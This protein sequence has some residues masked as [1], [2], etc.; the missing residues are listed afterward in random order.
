MANITLAQNEY[1]N[2]L[3]FHCTC[4]WD[5]QTLMALCQ[6][7]GW[8]VSVDKLVPESLEKVILIPKFLSENGGSRNPMILKMS[9]ALQI[10]TDASRRKGWDAH[11]GGH[12]ARGTWFLP[13]VHVYYLELKAVF[14][15]LSE[16]QDLCDRQ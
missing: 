10:F 5:I 8:I 4:L 14:L 9:L 6:E 12:P 1:L 15:A 13:E 16:F 11:L 7:L 3:Y 2:H